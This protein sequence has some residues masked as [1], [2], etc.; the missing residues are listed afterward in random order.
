MS[1]IVP[2]VFQR[3]IEPRIQVDV[4]AGS[5]LNSKSFHVGTEEGWASRFL[6]RR[7]VPLVAEFQPDIG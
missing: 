6:R 1:S 5:S 7:V 2:P 3:A 4:M